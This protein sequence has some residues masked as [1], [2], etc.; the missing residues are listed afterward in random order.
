MSR[1]GRHHDRGGGRVGADSV[2][3]SFGEPV[4]PRDR[5]PDAHQDGEE[6]AE[7]EMRER[8]SP[9]RTHATSC[10]WRVWQELSAE[11]GIAAICAPL[12]D[13]FIPRVLRQ[14][15]ID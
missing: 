7:E 9:V 5:Q 12:L 14:R 11:E 3:H 4:P 15:A 10:T 1:R 2:L 13:Q 6:N 8:S